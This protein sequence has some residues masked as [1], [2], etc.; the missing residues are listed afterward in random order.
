[1]LTPEIYF[2][3]FDYYLG[4]VS[5]FST[6][7][8]ENLANNIA[9]KSQLTM[10]LTE[11]SLVNEIDAILSFPDFHR[12]AYIF[13]FR[14]QAISN[15]SNKNTSLAALSYVLDYKYQMDLYSVAPFLKEQAKSAS[16]ILKSEYIY[17]HDDINN[18]PLTLSPKLS[19]VVQEF[20]SSEMLQ[21]YLDKIQNSTHNPKYKGS[22]TYLI[23]TFPKNLDILL[24]GLVSN[25][26]III[27][28]HEVIIPV[29][30]ECIQ[31]LIPFKLL[32][33]QVYT[34]TYLNS[35]DY[36]MIGIDDESLYK[37]YAKQNI[38]SV[39]IIKREISGP[40]QSKYF[41]LLIK[42][43]KDEKLTEEQSKELIHKE[44]ETILAK[45]SEIIELCNTIQFSQEFFTKLTRS[46]DK[47]LLQLALKIVS[48]YSPTIM[49]KF[50]VEEKIASYFA[51]F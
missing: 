26:P 15:D 28:G 18:G 32:K 1:M 29:V 43:V 6:T 9:L 37:E 12:I 14:I 13:V 24:Y 3:V 33:Y 41:Q 31:L 35:Q 19:S 21:S 44:M 17:I 48:Q 51:N 45:A 49:A 7:D 4:P 34:K 27:I 25:W 36:D 8:D 40:S 47:E 16:A 42:R 46:T 5:V 10:A 11:N 22:I 23:E 2:S 39:N 20:G 38:I 30:M 50:G